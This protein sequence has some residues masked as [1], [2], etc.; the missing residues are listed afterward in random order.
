[1][2]ISNYSSLQTRSTLDSSSAARPVNATQ[3]VDLDAS[4][5][6]VASQLN[7]DGQSKNDASLKSSVV[8]ESSLVSND[9]SEKQRLQEEQLITRQLAERDRE[10]KNHERIHAS[11]GGVHAS[12]P[13][14]SYERGPDGQLY[15]VEG[16]VRIDTS[17]IPDDPQATLEKAETIMR[18]ALSVPEPSTQDRRVAADARAMAAEARAEIAKAEQA[19][20]QEE[21]SQTTIE[22]ETE[23][24]K[25]RT[26]QD[27][28]TDKKS[29]FE[30]SAEKH[31]ADKAATQSLQAFNDRL[32]EIQKTL[33]KINL[34]LVEAGAFEKLF[35]EGSIIDKNV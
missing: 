29:P 9:A 20:Q 1:M 5:S 12:A 34:K 28:T 27:D 30:L 18:A 26:N 7:S 25:E 14:F 31:E 15:A 32:N 21:G 4:T 17:P 11:V 33:R 35:P 2:I 13:S 23:E 8:Y 19:K 3:K 10:V 6:P 24:T 16:E 22:E